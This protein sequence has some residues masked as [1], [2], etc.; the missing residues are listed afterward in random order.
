MA[1]SET[2]TKHQYD[3]E[4]VVAVVSYF[5]IIGWLIA[6]LMYGQYKSS[7]AR[8]HLRQSLGLVVLSAILSFIPLI[9]WVLNLGVIFFWFVAVYHCFIG[10]QYLVPAVGEFFQENFD[11][12]R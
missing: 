3:M 11:F 7:F 6:M 4:K 2:Q 9:G 10:Q 5:S 12:I 8:F 1:H